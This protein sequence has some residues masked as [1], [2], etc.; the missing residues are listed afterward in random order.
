MSATDTPIEKFPPVAVPVPATAEVQVLFVYSLTVDPASAEPLIAGELL[1]AGPAG[2][3]ER[4]VGAAGA[5]ESS[6]YVAEDDEQAD[7]LPDAS[8]ALAKNV[9]D[10]SSAT[11][12]AMPGEANVA[13]LPEPAMAD[14][15]VLFVY[16]LTVEPASADPMIFGELL[17][18]GEAGDV[19]VTFGAL[20]AVESST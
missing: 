18:A 19:D 11:E 1:F 2:V 7:V 8:L 12:T 6:T 14:V 13:A 3:L 15:Q 9:V 17:L 20:G 5:V 16:S 4:P 10:V